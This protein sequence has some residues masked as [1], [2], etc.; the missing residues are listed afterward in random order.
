MSDSQKWQKIQKNLKQLKDDFWSI[1]K[2]INNINLEKATKLDNLLYKLTERNNSYT[3]QQILEEL[4]ELIG[5]IYEKQN[6]SYDSVG[7]GNSENSTNQKIINNITNQNNSTVNNKPK[8]SNEILLR[9]LEYLEGMQ[10]P[11]VPNVQKVF[12]TNK[13]SIGY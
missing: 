8:D 6:V 5:L 1:S 3:L 7:S 4:K 11:V 9:I 12:V 10:L 13:D 2:A